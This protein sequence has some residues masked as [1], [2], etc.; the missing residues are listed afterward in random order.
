[1]NLATLISFASLVAI[2][3]SSACAAPADGAPHDDVDAAAQGPEASGELAPS[4]VDGANFC[5][6]IYYCAACPAG[7]GDGLACGSKPGIPLNICNNH[8]NVPCVVD[9]Y[10]D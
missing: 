10:C 9:S 4:S 2:S 5:S 1:M 8:C 7:H 3:L 6:S